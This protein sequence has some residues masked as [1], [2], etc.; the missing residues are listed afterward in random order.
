MPPLSVRWGRLTRLLLLAAVGSSLTGFARAD[1]RSSSDY[2]IDTWQA[3]HG[4]P[5]NTVTC[6][7]QTRDGY[8]WL[9]TFNGLARFDGVR[10]VVFGAHNTP[11]LKSNRILTLLE[12]REGGLWIGTEGGGVTRWHA[13]RFSTFSAWE[14]LAHDIVQCLC[15]DA[16]GRVWIGTLAGL[17]GW[18][19][20]ALFQLAAA[21]GLPGLAVRAAA[22]DAQGRC[23]WVAGD[24]LFALKD[25]RFAAEARGSFEGKGISG[26]HR[27][28]SGVV[29]LFGEGLLTPMGG[30]HSNHLQSAESA[31]LQ[32]QAVEESVTEDLWI[33]TRAGELRRRRAGQWLTIATSSEAV[34]HPVRC[35]CED[36][37]GNLWVGTDGGG[38]VRLKPRRLTTLGARDGLANEYILSMAGDGQGGVWLGANCGGITLWRDG[39]LR[40]WTAEGA[41]KP[42]A[43]VGP[44]LRTRD[45]S[46]WIGTSGEGLFRWKEGAA[47]RYGR[48]D[49]LP[50]PT[51][52]SL[53]EDREGRLWIGTYEAG[54]FQ[55]HD[56]KFRNFTAKEGFPARII[57]AIVQDRDGD[58]WIGSSGMGLYRYANG[59]FSFYSRREGW[60]SD[61]IRALLVDTEGALWIG[62]G[63]S[64]LTR[65]KDGWFHTLSTRHGLGDDVVSQ[66]LEDDFG[67]L[68]IGSN[69]GIFRVSKRSF[70]E[71]AAGRSVSVDV[72]AYGKSE[73]MQS[74][75]CT[76]GFHPAG[77]K[78]TDG[79][80][81]FSTVK[82]A[83]KIDPAL[84][85]GT[86]AT[87]STAR[88]RPSNVVPPPV[89]IEEVWGD[90][91]KLQSATRA[92]LEIGPGSK[93][94]EI[95]YT[96][97]SFTAPE[98]V[99]FKHRLAGLDTDW[100]E[101]GDAR[102]ARYS[103]LR[104]GEY[105]FQVIACNNDGVWNERGAVL[106]F[107]LR[108]H[109]WQTRWFLGAVVL[110]VLGS[111]AGGIRYR[112]RRKLR[113]E[114]ERLERQHA[115]EKERHRIAQDM[116]DE[117][118]SRLAKLS[119]MSELARSSV[120]KPEEARR[121]IDAIA[122]TSRSVL[123]TLDEIVWAVN[124]QNDTLEHLAAYIGE[125]AR[126]F[127]Q[128]TSIECK[129]QLPMSLPAHP[130]T[131][132]TRHHL[133]L[134]VQEAL[135]NVLKHAHATQVGVAMTLR[136]ASFEI[137]VED[138]GCGF[139]VAGSM[140]ANPAKETPAPSRSDRNGLTNMRQRLASIG[141][142]FQLE[143]RMGQ[144]TRVVF[145]LPVLTACDWRTQIAPV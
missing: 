44:L 91:E 21:E 121:R 71:F 70:E 93:R 15:E 46:L 17:S 116:H 79:T 18:R 128:M 62:S 131:A 123:E 38:L 26:L 74:L 45:G 58:L 11:E 118:G 3:E 78:A 117:L 67:H 114:M 98:K 52:L 22:G 133:F 20:G 31:A 65:M 127:F 53:C 111:I 102:V 56:G 4:L 125:Y 66:I 89:I 122:T 35:L 25:G 68:W 33:G 135:S 37:E 34:Q 63:G 47:T 81:W 113:R 82:G 36:R 143:S 54:L 85:A 5:Q 77:L 14:G 145:R 27:V 105:C 10:F 92:H 84:L 39:A 110:A 2:L 72:V 59:R 96:A 109:F 55:F 23:W 142:T 139:E 83:V 94:L 124:P 144:G 69:R 13:G 136:D 119:F 75:E 28:R 99:R 88:N 12:D 61:F 80:L 104:P 30:T 129:V 19:Q 106:A 29:W 97:L 140:E 103:Q 51:I 101:A 134:A 100:V 60:G 7:T 1:S 9:G 40:S 16:Q 130:L 141:A 90:D 120:E 8:L 76:G 50:D 49:G 24:S 107:S 137:A 138:N 95:R 132:E 73:G 41:L 126:Q 86:S 115:V 64:G 6:I 87:N 48:A 32:V 42:N 43:C 57:T 112:E 108:P